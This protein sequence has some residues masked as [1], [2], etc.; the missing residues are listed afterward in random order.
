MSQSIPVSVKVRSEKGRCSGEDHGAWLVRLADSV[1]EKRD[2]RLFMVHKLI[3]LGNQV[4]W[5]IAHGTGG[6]I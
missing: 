1:S 6:I 5:A 3:V 2:C 4:L